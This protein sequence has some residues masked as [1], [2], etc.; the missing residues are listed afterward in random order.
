MPGLGYA[1][2]PGRV[3]TKSTVLPPGPTSSSVSSST[4]L[5]STSSPFA[6]CYVPAK[7]NSTGNG[8]HNNGFIGSLTTNPD[9]NEEKPKLDPNDPRVKKLMYSMYREMLTSRN[10][11]ANDIISKKDPAKVTQDSGVGPILESIIM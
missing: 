2:T 8:N 10:S 1:P 7:R 6:V 11:E 3:A 9:N 4:S 5:Q